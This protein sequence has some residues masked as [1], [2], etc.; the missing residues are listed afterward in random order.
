MGSLAHAVKN[1][2]TRAHSPAR[3]RRKAAKGYRHNNILSQSSNSL[4]A[5]TISKGDWHFPFAEDS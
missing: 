5:W 1:M 4:N 3:S 2:V